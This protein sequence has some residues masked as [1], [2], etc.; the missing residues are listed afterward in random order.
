MLDLPQ[1]LR[2][3]RLMVSTTQQVN[4]RGWCYQTS[5][6]GLVS[7]AMVT[8]WNGNIFRVT[9]HLYGE[10]TGHWWIPRT[11]ASDAQV[12]V[13]FDLRLKERL[14]KQSLGW[15]YETP[16]RPLW[17]HSNG[18]QYFC[19]EPVNCHSVLRL[20]RFRYSFETHTNWT[21][22]H[23]VHNSVLLWVR[24]IHHAIYGMAEL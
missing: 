18:E 21:V 2:Q 24:N 8:S 23:T 5:V 13:F 19:D 15:W 14:S 9:G 22:S 11:K 17:R 20:L 12:D 10:F 4:A 6:S 7:I 3:W 16:S 1:T